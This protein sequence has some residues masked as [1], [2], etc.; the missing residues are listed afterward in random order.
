MEQMDR[1]KIS[2]GVEDLKEIVSKNGYYVDKTEMIKK[3]LDSNTKVTLFTRPRRFG[4]TLNQSM[5]RRFF[6][7]ERNENG[8]KIDNCWIFDG[9]LIGCSGEKYLQHQQKYPVINLSMKS[10]KQ[11]DFQLAC[12]MLKKEIV[13]EFE[14]HVYV[15]ASGKL[16]QSERESFERILRME[17]NAQLYSDALKLLAAYLEKYHKRKAII[18]IDEYD[19]PLENA[20]FCGFYDEMTGFI[21]SLFEPALKTNESLEFSVITGCLRI[22]KESI[23]TGLNNLKIDS[24]RN[25]QFGDS[26]GFTEAEVKELMGY[27]GLEAQF[28]EV[29]EWYDG[30]RF[31]KKEIYNPWSILNY[32]YE[33][34]NDSMDYPAPYWSNT[35]SNSIVGELV[36][37]ADKKTRDEIEQLLAGNRIEKPIHE[38]ITYEDIY[39]S[40]DNLWNFL[41]FTGYLKSVGESFRNAQEYMQ[42][43][44]PNQEIFTIYRNSVKDWFRSSIESADLS[45]LRQALEDGNC[46]A[47]G[48]IL[49][50]RLMTSISYYDYDE[51]YYHGFVI[52]LLS[53]MGGYDVLSNRESGEGRPDIVLREQ[54]FRGRA[55]LLELK[56][57]AGFPQMESACLAAL[58]Q[59]QDKKYE[60]GLLNEGYQI[61]GKYGVSFFREGCLVM[62]R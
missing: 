56:I 29:K 33:R 2:I 18:L 26:F 7:D 12:A 41:Y 35:S 22:S 42:L 62:K 48:D 46:E 38:D 24:I 6:E 43:A 28:R 4:K 23:F 31:G 8:E 25:D 53:G 47:V 10:G 32:I 5:V 17:D 16:T 1:K 30:Y 27:Y 59:I 57:A 20:Y 15:L 52:G 44:I 55:F 39:R 3:L 11:P 50:E 14:R 19:V 21:R 34:V 37:R 51:H 54:R 45:P 9:L 40:Q 13:R 58:D 60:E 61:A 49:S 36:Y